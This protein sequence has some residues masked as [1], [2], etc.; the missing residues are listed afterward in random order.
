MI[1]HKAFTDHLKRI[2]TRAM[3]EKDTKKFN[4]ALRTLQY[5]IQEIIIH[6][7]RFA[8]KP[9]ELVELERDVY[10][11]AYELAKVGG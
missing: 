1:T 7:P 8:T 2:F 9:K 11:E 10:R 3:L 6:N 5:A 4:A